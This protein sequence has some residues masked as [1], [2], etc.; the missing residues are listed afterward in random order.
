VFI[1]PCL[2][3]I[4]R[5]VPTGPQWAYEIKHD[6]FHFLAVRQ[7][8]QVRI[9]SRGGHDW[10][11]RLPAITKAL[12]ALPVRSVVLDGEGV[13]CGRDGRSEFD[14]MRAC[15]SRNGAPQACTPSTCWSSMI[16]AFFRR[17][18]RFTD[19]ASGALRRQRGAGRAN[20]PLPRTDVLV[21]TWTVDE[22]HDLTFFVVPRSSKGRM[23]RKSGLGLN[24]CSRSCHLPLSLT[25]QPTEDCGEQPR[26]WH[27]KDP[28]DDDIARYIPTDR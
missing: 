14:Q 15:F 22:G 2:L 25:Y 28:S 3:T 18:S 12:L 24:W 17:L 20:S 26:G 1:E 16:F 10:S 23:R 21:V 27:R 9:H 11:E 5:S 6:G 7:R 19:T 4:S 8:K 13:I